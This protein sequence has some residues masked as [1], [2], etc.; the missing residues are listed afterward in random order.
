MKPNIFKYLSL[1]VVILAT[2]R[3]IDC[4]A[5]LNTYGN[6][7]LN[8]TCKSVQDCTGAAL[9]GDCS[10][11]T[12][13]CCVDDR[14]VQVAEHKKLTKRLFLKLVGNTTRNN[15]MYNYVVE[16]MKLAAIEGK[17][18]DFKIAAYLAQLVGETNYFQKLESGI[19]D[20][21]EDQDQNDKKTY[22]GRGGILIRGKANYELANK[23]SAYS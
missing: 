13:V 15:A 5:C 17:N 10:S 1:F 6:N 9:I 16:S 7:R 4:Q 19:I 2:L 21:D 23:S 14:T 12:M 11:Q 18:E 22:Q 20:G 3:S 8:G